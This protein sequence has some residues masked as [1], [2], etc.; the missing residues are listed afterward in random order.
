MLPRLQLLLLLLQLQLQLL[1]LLRFLRFLLL[2]LLLPVRRRRRRRMVLLLLLLLLPLRLYCLHRRID[3]QIC[4][5]H[6][7]WHH[8]RDS[9]GAHH[10]LRPTARVPLLLL[11][12][13]LRRPRRR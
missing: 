6:S 2:L 10:L 12:P 8:R 13:L 5:A 7:E 4:L 9:R 3:V 1:L 11:L